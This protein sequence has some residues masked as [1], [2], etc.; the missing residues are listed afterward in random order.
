MAY[1]LSALA[2]FGLVSIYVLLIERRRWKK[3]ALLAF[4]MLLIPEISAD[5]KL[6]HI[7]LPLFVF[8]NAPP[9]EK[10]DWFYACM[11]ALLLIPKNYFFVASL[12]T[13]AGP[14]TYS[15]GAILNPLIMLAMS[16]VIIVRGLRSRLPD[17]G[18]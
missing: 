16:A 4:S 6:L 11:F 15:I 5:Y 17:S 8:L 7:F 12:T 3:V 14:G 10:S 1:R 18:S 2:L 9:S 13:D